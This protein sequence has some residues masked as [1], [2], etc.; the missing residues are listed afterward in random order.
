MRY[1]V[2]RN[3]IYT[4]V[5]RPTPPNKGESNMARIEPDPV[6]LEGTK[7]RETELAIQFK[8]HKVNGK[9]LPEP[10]TTWFPRSQMKSSLTLAPL[11]QSVDESETFDWMKMSHW[12]C[13]TKG[14]V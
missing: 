12:I 1:G 2:M 10:L 9:D 4:A 14:L 6:M 11:P 13:S 7:L 5:A 3:G 8:V